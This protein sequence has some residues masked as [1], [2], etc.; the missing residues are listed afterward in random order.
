MVLEKVL[1]DDRYPVNV[2]EVA[3]EFSR[4][5]EAEDRII[6]VEGT[7]LPGFDGALVRVPRKGWG[8]L[9]NTGIASPGRVNYTL[10][11]ELGHYLVHRARYPQGLRCSSEDLASGSGVERIVEREADQFAADLLM[12]YPDLRKHLP[13]AS[14]P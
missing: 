11:H 1:G 14:I 5:F 12:P 9:Y 7:D 10:G 8:I 3:V 13:P 2:P 4:Q 6:R